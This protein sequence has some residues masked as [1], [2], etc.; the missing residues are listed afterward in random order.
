MASEVR[1]YHLV[2]LTFPLRRFAPRQ[3]AGRWIQY[4]PLAS[5]LPAD[6]FVNLEKGLTPKRRRGW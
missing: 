6:A 2:A 1:P 3:R 4:A 5:I